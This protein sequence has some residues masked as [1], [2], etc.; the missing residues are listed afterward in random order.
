M[1]VPKVPIDVHLRKR[2]GRTI[3]YCGHCPYPIVAYNTYRQTP[4]PSCC[5]PPIGIDPHSCRPIVGPIAYPIG[6]YPGYKEG[7]DG[8]QT[9]RS[10]ALQ[11]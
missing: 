2:I 4:K 1:L 8:S 7:L 9:D 11:A 3:G 10:K 6:Y 5:T